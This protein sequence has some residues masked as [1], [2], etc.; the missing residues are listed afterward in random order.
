MQ[1][2]GQRPLFVRRRLLLPGGDLSDD[3]GD[4]TASRSAVTEFAE[5]DALPCAEVEPA[6]G[7]GNREFDPGERRFGMGGHVVVAFERMDVVG[8]AL[9]HQPVENRPEVGAYVGVGVLVDGKPGRGVPDEKVY[10]PCIGQRREVGYDLVRDQV[11]PA[12]AGAER[13]FGLTYHGG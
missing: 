11:K 5:V 3:G 9:A 10:Q 6:P 7:D 8:F 12:A 2:P 1:I 13:E 4:D